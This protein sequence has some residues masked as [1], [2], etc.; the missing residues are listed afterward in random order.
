MNLFLAVALPW[1]KGYRPYTGLLLQHA[2]ALKNG[3]K[4]RISAILNASL[5]LWSRFVPIP[6]TTCVMFDNSWTKIES[7][8]I[9]LA[10]ENQFD[11]VWIE[12]TLSWPFAEKILQYFPNS[13]LV[14]CSGHNVESR[15]CQRL[16]DSKQ[17]SP[18][19]DYFSAQTRLMNRMELSAWKK[20]DIIFHCSDADAKF[21]RAAIPH[22]KVFVV[23]N[24]VDTQYFQRSSTS[25]ISPNPTILFTAGFG[26][27]PNIEAVEW[28]LE[29]VFTKVLQSVPN[30]R[31]LFA[32]S[33]AFSLQQKLASK[34][35]DFGDSIECVSDPVDIRPY[36]EKAWVYIVPLQYGGGTRL[37]ILEAMAMQLPVVSTTVGAE[38]VPYVKD[39]HLLLADSPEDFRKAIVH[40]LDNRERRQELSNAGYDFVTQNYDWQRIRQQTLQI[41]RENCQ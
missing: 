33:E 8:A 13:P 31:F 3:K 14:L 30:C 6:P 12:H 11:V 26:Y 2:T 27:H 15:V 38:G 24:G 22:G 32:G 19:Y 35:R 9:K 39:K 36:F 1:R 37:K 21:T 25:T 40:L 10:R 20:S 17:N 28:F 7:E 5:N 4:T 41:L 34:L 18:V 16:Q 29:H 23:P